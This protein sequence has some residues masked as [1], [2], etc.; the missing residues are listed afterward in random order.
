ML[1]QKPFDLIGVEFAELG[2]LAL[3][4]PLDGAGEAAVLDVRNDLALLELAPTRPSLIEKGELRF[5]AL[6]R[7]VMK[8]INF[9]PASATHQLQ[10]LSE[11]TEVVEVN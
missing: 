6:A 10:Q 1:H 3:Q 9:L 4:H 5:F 7:K 2:L 8:F 11:P